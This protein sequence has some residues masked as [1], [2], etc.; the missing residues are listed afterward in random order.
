MLADAP[1]SV[2]LAREALTLAERFRLHE[3]VAQALITLGVARWKTGD[4]GGQTDVEHGLDLALEYNALSAA[5]RGYNN[6][7]F[8]A[9]NRGRRDERLELLRKAERLGHRLGNPDQTRFV[10]AQLIA[11]IWARG[12]WDEA[13]ERANQF[14]AE[15]EAG[16]AH[17]QEP[18][19]R[20]MR[21][22]AR[23]ARDDEAGALED[24]EKG[25]ALARKNEAPESLIQTVGNA[26]EN[27]MRLGRLDQARAVAQEA[28][29]FDPAVAAF[30][31]LI[32]L[33]WD[34]DRLGINDKELEAYLDHLPPELEETRLCRLIIA[35]DFTQL[36]ERM[37]DHGQRHFEAD[38]RLR[39]AQQLAGQGQHADAA[40]QAE[41]AAAFYRSVRA[42]RSLRE[43]QAL[44]DEIHSTIG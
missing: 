34:K 5:F 42:T 31:L 36:A 30:Y 14:I 20:M 4:L 11:E 2:A 41:K 7:A 1:E 25:L 44:L 13:F 38:I 9:G 37:A 29:S 27:Y 19:L 16:S 28:R 33:A 10:Q 18:W 8:L 24:I 12:D 15:C 26:I 21:A 39:A 22:R 6:L 40:A 3:L 32:D 43:A 35:G 23:I 17:V